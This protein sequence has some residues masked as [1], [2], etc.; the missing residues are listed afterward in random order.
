MVTMLANEAPPM[1]Q[2]LQPQSKRMIETEA[3]VLHAGRAN[4]TAEPEPA[5]LRQEVFAFSD[6][7]EEEVLVE[8]VCGCWEA[9]MTHALERK[10][11]DICHLRK[12]PR[13]VVGNAGVVKVLAIGSAVTTVAEGDLC[14]LFCN[15]IWDAHGYPIKIVAYD[16]P[17]TMGVLAKQ[18]KLHEKQ[19]IRIPQPS[20]YSVAQWAAFSL[21]YITAWANWHVSHRCWQAQMD[22]VPPEDIY[23][24]AWGG[25]VSLAEC[26]LAKH[27]GNQALMLASGDVRMQTGTDAGITMIDRRTFGEL[28]YDEKRYKVDGDYRQA[29]QQAEN[30]FVDTMMTQ[31]NDQGVAIFIDNIGTPVYRATL[32]TLARQ[33]V[34]TTCGWKH[35]MKIYNVRAIECISRHTHVHTHYARYEDAVESV[36]FAHETG[37]FP[38]INDEDIYGWDEI[39]QLAADYAQDRIE[40]YFPIFTVE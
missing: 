6:I 16:A 22:A 10:P 29:Y 31:T 1:E 12:E 34:V 25:G 9:N 37:W 33:G 26:T 14:I 3:W 7:T 24:A 18:L 17:N 30:A 19:V 4:G 11:V 21:R 38:I 36:A 5:E 13:V 20:P 40:S 15:G 23:V 8:T 28:N 39:P 35:G 2:M 32:K 27:Y